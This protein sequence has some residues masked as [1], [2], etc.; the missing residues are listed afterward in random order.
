MAEQHFPAVQVVENAVILQLLTQVAHPIS[1]KGN[2]E[3]KQV[4]QRRLAAVQQWEP[5]FLVYFC[6]SF[7]E[8]A[9]ALQFTQI[10][11]TTLTHPSG[12]TISLLKP[13]QL[14]PQSLWDLCLN[15]GQLI[16]FLRLPSHDVIVGSTLKTLFSNFYRLGGNKLM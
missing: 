16:D 4:F 8:A 14:P 15:H 12:Y 6:G 7:Q 9:N 13:V 3:E 11:L 5:V 1:E 10:G 2:E